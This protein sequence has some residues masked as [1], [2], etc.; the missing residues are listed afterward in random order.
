MPSGNKT[1]FAGAD[2]VQRRSRDT[3]AQ[4]K[5]GLLADAGGKPKPSGSTER[6]SLSEGQRLCQASRSFEEGNRFPRQKPRS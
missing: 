3:L 4:E 1:S 5:P 2:D 6:A